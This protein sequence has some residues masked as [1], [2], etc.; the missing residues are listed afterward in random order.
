MGQLLHRNIKFNFTI[1]LSIA[2]KCLNITIL[3]KPRGFFYLYK[4][5]NEFLQC[6]FAFKCK[7]IISKID[8]SLQS[9][10]LL[11]TKSE[12]STIILKWF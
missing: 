11:T 8:E 2:I 9:R 12:Q 4:V 10:N 6:V 3:G 7:S 5:F 1:H